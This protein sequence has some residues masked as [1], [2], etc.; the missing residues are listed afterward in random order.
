MPPAAGSDVNRATMRPTRP[1]DR[2]MWP[3]PAIPEIAGETSGCPLTCIVPC[4][5]SI[6]IV[7]R[8]PRLNPP[9]RRRRHGVE[10][11]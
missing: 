10:K 5:T 6:V 1:T 4:T 2:P 8:K 7:S 3:R 11:G 9:E